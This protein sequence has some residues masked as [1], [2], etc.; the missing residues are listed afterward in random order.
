MMT[1]QITPTNVTQK[2]L[3][4][5]PWAPKSEKVYW[6]AMRRRLGMTTRSVTRMAQPPIHPDLGPMAR[7]TQVN[8]VPQSGSARFM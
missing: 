6:P 3:V 8:V 7:V 1:I 5:K 4:A 2:V